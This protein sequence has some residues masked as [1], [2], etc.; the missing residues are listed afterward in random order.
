MLWRRT[1]RSHSTTPSASTAIGSSARNA[2]S[3]RGRASSPAA[4]RMPPP[5]RLSV[6]MAGNA[7]ARSP[8]L[9]GG[10][11]DRGRGLAEQDG[12]LLGSADAALVRVDRLR[13]VVGAHHRRPRAD[14]LEPALEMRKIPELLALPLVGHDPGIARHV[15]DRIVAGDEGA[16]GKP[17][18]EH[19]VEPV[20]LVAIA[21]HGIGNLVHRVMAEVV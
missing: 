12:A 15:G 14:R 4:A 17:P 16:I 5:F 7:G 1:T 19:A 3:S 20:H 18:V 21:V 13:L 2:R 11:L 8:R 6:T 10:A 9:R